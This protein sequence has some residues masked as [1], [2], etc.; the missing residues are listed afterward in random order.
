MQPR[1]I[2]P[3]LMTVLVGTVGCG[4]D[5]DNPTG[6]TTST[7]SSSSSS[8]S[9]SGM[10]GAGG[11]G[12]GGMGGMPNVPAEQQVTEHFEMIRADHAAVVDLIQKMPKGGDLHNHTSGAVTPE[13]MI[14]WGAADGACFNTMTG[15]ASAGPCQMGTVPISNALNDQALYDTIMTA[16]SMEGFQGT[17]LEKH[18]HFFDAF[19]KFGAILTNERSD[20]ML[21]QV[22]STAGKNNQIYIELMQGFGSSSVGKIADTKFMMGDM[23]DEATLLQRRLD[24]LADP[25]FQTA[26]DSAKAG[27]A[28][29]LSGSDSLLNC[30][31]A[32]ADPGCKVDVRFM[33][34]GTRTQSRAYVFG[35]W[36]FAFELTQV[37]P[38]MV[39][40]NL[41][42][43]EEHANSLLYYDD[44]MYAVG[45]LRA[46]N[47]KDPARKPVHVGL[48]AGE[49]IPEVLP[50]TP[51]GQAEL[52]YHIR[53]AV[54]MGGAER[55]GHGVD[56]LGET[57][58]A[59]VDDLLMGMAQK[60]VM[61]EI[62][63]TSNDT[64][65]GVNGSNHPFATYMSKGV[66]VAPATDD[67][68]ILRID[69]TDEYVRA[70][71]EHKLDYPAL[72]KLSRTSLEHAF[73]E[74]MSLW[75][76]GDDFTAMVLEC[77]SDVPG[78]PPSSGCD[79][80]L[81]ANKKAQIQWQ[82]EVNLAAFEQSI[83]KP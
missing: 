39:G 48:H 64:L 66:P 52:T 3:L 65:L 27:I 73:V 67:E 4:D 7:S 80:Y 5:T 53:N 1:F 17:L 49:L 50:M 71:E 51:Q 19:G 69:I 70:F 58:G 23:W 68:G 79:T 74:G 72:K 42:A 26:I 34:A 40:V 59:G 61:V 2:L 10:G 46:F 81:N 12:T 25:G 38:E 11:G 21:A 37:V 35:Q 29:T 6:G 75:A 57:A 30:G 55:I 47:E 20:D 32:M 22:R 82:H 45:I 16:W 14:E 9:S 24:I 13:S 54:D 76:K 36:V 41:V 33:V 18:Q 77:A 15:F 43:P 83:A 60:R 78:M 44:E 62:C 56:V 63:L 8:S 31:T 28:A